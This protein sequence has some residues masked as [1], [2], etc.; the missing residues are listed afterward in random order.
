M[1]G[2]SCEFATKRVERAA[3]A[4]PMSRQHVLLARSGKLAEADSQSKARL[5]GMDWAGLVAAI[6]DE[7][8]G[9]EEI[10]PDVAAQRQGYVDYLT[11]RLDASDAFVQ[12]AEKGR[13]GNG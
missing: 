7:W 12:E 11:A 4:F 10:F 2:S 1:S 5:T 9:G 6:P 8:L 3:S 13:T